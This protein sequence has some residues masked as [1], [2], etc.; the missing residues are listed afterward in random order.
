MTT[1]PFLLIFYTGGASLRLRSGQAFA[2][3]MPAPLNS[4]GHAEKKKKNLLGAKKV[5]E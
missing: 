2:S 5:E 1:S 3:W 4:G